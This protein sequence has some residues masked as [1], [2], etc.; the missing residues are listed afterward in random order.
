MTRP[1]PVVPRYGASTLADL[2]PSVGGVLGQPGMA[3]RLALPEADRFVVFLVDGLGDALIEAH[4]DL[5]PTLTALRGNGSSR[6]LTC[7]VPS[8][9]V[10]SVTSLGTGLPPGQHGMAGY[11][12]RFGGRVL[13]AL[14]WQDGLHGLDVQP[15]LTSFERLSK[16]GIACATVVPARFRGTGLTTS[17]LRGARFEGLQ[18]QDPADRL[19]ESAVACSAIGSRSVVYAYERDLDHAGH[20]HGTDS[21][22]WRDELVRIDRLVADLR[23]ALPDDVRLIVT[24]DHGMV[25]IGPESRVVVEDEPELA[26]DL[27]LVAGEGRLRQLYTGRPEAVAARWRDRWGDAAWVRTRDEAVD[28][29]WFGPMSGRLA[30]RFG[31]V[32]VAMATDRAVLTTTQPNEFALIGMH[33]SLTAAEMTVPLLVG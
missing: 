6:A 3:N 10:T 22:Q 28:D 29:G 31:D 19:I 21:S 7:G 16:A 4:P 23:L 26:A 1:E 25:N 12:F 11:T 9:T 17:A 5:A 14:L 24:G 27:T 32:L 33:G 13:N 2:L 20:R 30:D 8:T 15:Q 18:P